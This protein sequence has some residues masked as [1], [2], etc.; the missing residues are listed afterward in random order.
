MLRPNYESMVELDTKFLVH[1]MEKIHKQQL[2][3]AESRA[4]KA[5]LSIKKLHGL[6]SCVI[7][8]SGGAGADRYGSSILY[9]K[10]RN[11][12]WNKNKS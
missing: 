8:A 12:L 11:I 3:K 2:Q 9:Y 6:R 10:F 4:L 7:V 1:N 5:E